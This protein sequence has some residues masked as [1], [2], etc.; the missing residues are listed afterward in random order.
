MGYE[1]ARDHRLLTAAEEVRLAQLI[2]AGVTGGDPTTLAAAERARRRMIECN[3]R[4]AMKMARQHRAPAHVDRDD[5]IQDA[6]LGLERAVSDYD[7]RKGY[8]FSTYASWWIRHSI[9]TGLETTVGSVRVPA[10]RTQEL[11]AA[12]AEADGDVDRLCARLGAT[13]AVSSM[14]SL[15]RTP[16]GGDGQSLGDR[17]VA[18]DG[19]PLEQVVAK[20]DRAAV[21]H[22]LTALDET[23]RYVVARRFGLGGREPA[24][25]AELGSE[26][27]VSPEAARRR[28][29]RALKRLEPVATE[30]AA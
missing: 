28:V 12:L 10:Q 3:L 9:Q 24:S 19:D 11:H 27:G 30:L 13:F 2:E 22:L 5:M 20:S 23:N 26:L 7:W 18:I 25:F 1:A 8:R 21:A 15:D 14:M 6:I 29:L 17:V 16:A 4:L